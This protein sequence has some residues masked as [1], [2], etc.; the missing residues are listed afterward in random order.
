MLYNE[1]VMYNF[2]PGNRSC[3]KHSLRT[4]FQPFGVPPNATFLSQIF[5]GAVSFPKARLLFNIW[6]GVLD[7]VNYAMIFTEHGCFPLFSTF[8]QTQGWFFKSF[9]DITMGIQDPNIFKPPVEC[10]DL[11]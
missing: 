9:N 10:T 8:Y 1:S 6:G 11:L 4:P 7:R 3:V 5:S 2:F